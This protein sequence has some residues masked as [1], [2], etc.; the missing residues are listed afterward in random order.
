MKFF[1]TGSVDAGVVLSKEISNTTRGWNTGI[2]TSINLNAGGSLVFKERI[3]LRTEVGVLFYSANY[4]NEDLTYTVLIYYPHISLTPH[5]IFPMKTSDSYFHIGCQLG[6]MFYAS[7]E[8][9]T[10]ESDVEFATIGQAGRPAFYSPEIGI[11]RVEGRMTI[12]ILGTYFYQSFEEPLTRTKITDDNGVFVGT[13]KGDY[14]GIRVGVAFELRPRKE[15]T[16]P[17]PIYVQTPEE[18]DNFASRDNAVIKQ[19]KTG[20]RFIKL[21]LYESGEIDNDSISVSVNGRYIL[22]QHSLEKKKVK[23]RIPLEKGTNTITVYAH[24]EGD[25]PPNTASCFIRYG[26]RKTTFPV[27]TSM[28]RNATVLIERK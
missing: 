3:G 21:R 7:D 4:S 11:T 16:E 10:N 26:L 19:I 22:T 28:K 1:A 12:S 18:S 5:F 27:S 15:K 13:C 9:I 17:E 8:L 20:R 23:L 2:G 24:N 6:R 25:I 14:P